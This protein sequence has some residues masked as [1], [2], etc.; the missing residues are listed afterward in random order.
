MDTEKV[1]KPQLKVT[2][3]AEKVY[4]C[5]ILESIYQVFSAL[6]CLQPFYSLDFCLSFSFYIALHPGFF[7][8]RKY[9]AENEPASFAC[10]SS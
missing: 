6:H 7:A 8:R 1:E 5:L 4:F 2:E 10:S 3:A 9:S